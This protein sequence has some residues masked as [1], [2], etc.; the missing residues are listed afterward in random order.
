MTL[1]ALKKVTVCGLTMEK[2]RVLNGLQDLG[3]LHLV[4]L[5]PPPA[6]PERAASPHAD[7]VVQALR[8][9]SRT[10]VKRRQLPRD[11]SFDV[12]AVAAEALEIKQGLREA[13]DK[14]DFL[15]QRIKDVIPWGDLVFPPHEQLAGYRLWFYILPAGRT[16]ALQ[17]IDLPWQIVHRDQRRTHVV[18]I[19]RDE[20]PTD[21]LPVPRTHTGSKPLNELQLELE[22]TEA[23]IEALMARRLALTRY[24]YLINLNLASAEN[25][26]SLDHATQQTRDEDGVFAVQGWAPVA[27][28][29]RLGEFASE[30][31]LAMLAE[32]PADDEQPPTLLKNRPA[33]GA[34]TDL[35]LFY[36]TP[37]YRTWD[38]SLVVFFSFTLFFAMILSDAGYA[39]V[40][41]VFLGLIWRK[42]GRSDGGKRM[43]NLFAWLLG[44]SFV[45]GVLV[46]GYFGVTPD[47]GTWLGALHVINLQNFNA[48]MELSIAVG[49][50]HLV[51]ANLIVA[52]NN[53]RHLGLMASKVGW[54]LFLIGGFTAYA[55]GGAGDAATVGFVLVAVGIAFVFLFTSQRP[56]KKPLDLV[57][58]VLD[59]LRA[60]TDIT[61][62]F[63]DVLSYMRL[64]ALGLASASLALTF[65]QLAGEVSGD[66]PGLGLLLELLILLVGHTLNIGLAIM[67][68]VVHGLR[69]NYI[70]F[71]NWGM[72]GEGY[73]F[74][75]FARKEVQR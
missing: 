60:V 20:P 41:A 55:G 65:N 75:A 11:P 35:A 12:S 3:C 14:R 18:I 13:T 17:R 21:L 69:L 24:I 58:R 74:R 15:E 45:W 29:K 67:S 42:M 1:V 64:F 30:H 16:K 54:S 68:G 32:E 47:P 7:D 70:E 36:Q 33:L 56:L 31:G 52:Y 61:K 63:G 25:A 40:L 2:Q 44:G 48:M 53:R 10:K 72:E 46:G 4:P 6:E 8:F 50:A 34:G 23:E 5:R 51:L 59:G 66:V 43:R 19:A 37:G 22:E 26:A 73:P 62:A 28:L 71:Y 9:L 57:W 38:P 49:V 27:D 39:V